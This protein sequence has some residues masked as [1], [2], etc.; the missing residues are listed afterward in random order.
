MDFEGDEYDYAIELR[1]D[2]EYRQTVEALPRVVD[3]D[4]EH[5]KDLLS[6]TPSLH[7]RSLAEK[8]SRSPQAGISP[9]KA[10]WSSS[11]PVFIELPR[12]KID[13][14]VKY[15]PANSDGKESIVSIGGSISKGQ[16]GNVLTGIGVISKPE[17][18]WRMELLTKHKK[19]AESAAR[20]SSLSF[21]AQFSLTDK[22]VMDKFLVA[23]SSGVNL[24][25]HQAK[26]SSELVIITSGNGCRTFKWKPFDR[27]YQAKLMKLEGLQGHDINYSSPL[28]RGGDNGGFDF[29]IRSETSFFLAYIITLVFT[30][31][32]YLLVCSCGDDLHS[33]NDPFDSERNAITINGDNDSGTVKSSRAPKQSSCFDNFG[34]KRSG[35]FEDLNILAV[36]PAKREDPTCTGQFGTDAF[37]RSHDVYDEELSF[38]VIYQSMNSDGFSTL[39]ME[40]DN[41]ELYLLL[42]R[43]FHLLRV[44][45]D[46]KRKDDNSYD[47]YGPKNPHNFSLWRSTSSIFNPT[48]PAVKS[49]PIYALFESNET[50]TFRLFGGNKKP[51]GHEKVASSTLPPAQ[52]LGWNSAGTQIWA[53]LKMAGLEVQCVYAWDLSR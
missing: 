6:Y 36:H 7:Q 5:V 17:F 47:E 26:H 49:D 33:G 29:C 31:L 13:D 22:A 43:G 25:R 51:H 46:A 9:N 27:I 41:L 10:L 52:F 18:S 16:S 23:L 45:A 32:C 20:K 53:R 40:C 14:Q 21:Y 12:N 37:R 11:S 38:S 39:D 1:P 24:R 15:S 48:G 44:E 4:L 50:D 28:S 30:Y 19:W 34:Y 42:L 3:L 8:N 2:D 35:R